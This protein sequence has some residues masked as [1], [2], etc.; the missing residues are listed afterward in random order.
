MRSSRRVPRDSTP[1]AVYVSTV[2]R[3]L[4][5]LTKFVDHLVG[6]DS[7][8]RA[9]LLDDV[10]ADV[11]ALLK[12]RARPAAPRV[13]QEEASEQDLPLE[14]IGAPEGPKLTVDGHDSVRRFANQACASNLGPIR[15]TSSAIDVCSPC[16]HPAGPARAIVFLLPRAAID[17]LAR[18]RARRGARRRQHR[19]A[20][21]D[22]RFRVLEHNGVARL[23]QRQQLHARVPGRYVYLRGDGGMTGTRAPADTRMSGS[24]PSRRL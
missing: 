10:P 9:T 23:P 1:S 13:K 19:P 3:Q 20:A 17:R 18:G 5:T 16:L 24:P 22:D 2:E 21:G 11:A 12:S 15:A 4:A 7:V 14:E 8:T 6:A